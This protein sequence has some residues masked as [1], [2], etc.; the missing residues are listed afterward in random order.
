MLARTMP[1][2][3]AAMSLLQT[4]KTILEFQD[5]LKLLTLGMLLGFS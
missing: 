5:G 1:N 2:D 3:F 4:L